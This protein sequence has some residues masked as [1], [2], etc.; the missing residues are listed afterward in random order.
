MVRKYHFPKSESDRIHVGIKT[1]EKKPSAARHTTQ[2]RY[3]GDIRGEPW[4]VNAIPRSPHLYT[5][6]PERTMV[7]QPEP[8]RVHIW[9]MPGN[10]YTQSIVSEFPE[11]RIDFFAVPKH[12]QLSTAYVWELRYT[13][14]HP[15]QMSTFNGVV[16]EFP[17]KKRRPQ[18]DIWVCRDK[19]RKEGT[20]TLI[21]HVEQTGDQGF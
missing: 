9:I 6:Y 2:H 12:C 10:S 14:R 8:D 13:N 11:I 18:T 19:A 1:L 15:L 5:G 7:R 20:T 21:R 17:D 16:S 4:F 3:T